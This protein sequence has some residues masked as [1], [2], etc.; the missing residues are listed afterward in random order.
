MELKQTGTKQWDTVACGGATIHDLNGSNSGGYDG[1]NDRLRD[2]ADKNTLQNMAL[3][4]IIPGR[5]KQI[6]FVKKYQPKV[7]T[8]TAGGNDVGFGKKIKSCI[9]PRVSILTCD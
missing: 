6:E 1:Q 9:D 5:V 2:Y 7:I 3:N 8:L 4:E